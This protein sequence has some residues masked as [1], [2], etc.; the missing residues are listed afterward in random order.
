MTAELVR[1][2]IKKKGVSRCTSGNERTT[3]ICVTLLLQLHR[4]DLYAF[5]KPRDLLARY[6]VL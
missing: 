1:C 2:L 5:R 3:R 6:V 4:P